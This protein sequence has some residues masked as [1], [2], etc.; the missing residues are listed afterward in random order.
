M[1]GA[2][3]LAMAQYAAE[4]VPPPVTRKNEGVTAPTEVNSVRRSSD[5]MTMASTAARAESG[6]KAES[7]ASAVKRIITAITIGMGGGTFDLRLRVMA[8]LP[9][10]AFSGRRAYRGESEPDYG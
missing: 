9:S 6:R 4:P 7:A 1:R 3:M 10:T 5:W 8:S 2:F